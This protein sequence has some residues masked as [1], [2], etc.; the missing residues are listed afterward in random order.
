MNK[1]CLV[2]FDEMNIDTCYSSGAWLYKTRKW[3]KIKFFEG[4]NK[5]NKFYCQKFI[6]TESI[7]PW[8]G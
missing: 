1:A 6:L 4:E 3:P 5:R 7:Q 2:N 8:R